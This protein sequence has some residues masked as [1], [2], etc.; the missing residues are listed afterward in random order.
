MTQ[1][2][3]FRSAEQYDSE[4]DTDAVAD[5]VIAAKVNHRVY[6]T[7]VSISAS[8][9]P[10]ASVVATLGSTSIPAAD[11]FRLP[12]AAFSPIVINYNYPLRFGINEAV[13][14][15]LPALGAAVIGTV[16]IRGFYKQE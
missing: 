3:H 16:V 8:D 15:T 2:A 11:L 6:V 10:V 1:S 9:A 12:V 13:T 7:G 14:L 4:S 5:A